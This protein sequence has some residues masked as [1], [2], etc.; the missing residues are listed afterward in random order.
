M[1][2]Y[3]FFRVFTLAPGSKHAACEPGR[4]LRQS[5]TLFR[6]GH[7]QSTLGQ[8]V[9]KRQSSNACAPDQ[10]IHEVAPT[11]NLHM[12]VFQLCSLF[13]R[14]C[15]APQRQA[16]ASQWVRSFRR[17]LRRSASINCARQ[18]HYPFASMTWIR[19]FGSPH[20][21]RRSRSAVSQPLFG[22]P[23]VSLFHAFE[24]NGLS[25]LPGRKSALNPII[26]P[27][28]GQKAA[29]LGKRFQSNGLQVVRRGR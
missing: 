21:A 27:D 17:G 29:D 19:F 6:D 12:T 1:N 2:E 3:G 16:T 14:T 4:A 7:R 18:D 10:D 13:C 11:D 25:R 22:A 9:S 5:I 24:V 20:H 28:T 8:F 26:G 23:R 15:T